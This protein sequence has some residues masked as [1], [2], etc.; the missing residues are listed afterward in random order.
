MLSFQMRYVT[1]KFGCLSR[2]SVF[3]SWF[4]LVNVYL[5]MLIG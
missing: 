5:M 4:F 2:A 3:S 1:V